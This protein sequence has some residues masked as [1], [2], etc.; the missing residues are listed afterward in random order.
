MNGNFSGVTNFIW[1]IADLLRDIYKRKDYPDVILPFTVLRRLDCVLS[2]T[3]EPV[4]ETYEKYYGKLEDPSAVLM[5]ASGHN[6]YNVS[7]YDFKK[8]LSDPEN[9]KQNMFDYINGFSQNMVEVMER[10]KLR[11]R[12]NYLAEKDLLFKVVQ[13][14]S[15]VDLSPEAVSNH[16]MGYIFEE[17]IRKFSEENNEEAGEHFT[18]REIIRLMVNILMSE[19]K[20]RLSKPGIITTVYDPACGTGGMLTV[21][22][23]HILSD[24]N[25]NAN[26]ELF[27]QEINDETFAVCKSDMI[28]KGENPDNIKPDS[29]FSHDGFLN[30]SFDYILSNPPFGKDWRQDQKFIEDEHERGF[31]G[32]FGAGLPRIDDGQF[33]FLQHMISKMHSP[34]SGERTRIAIVFNGS[35]LFTG[36]AGSGESEIRRWIIENDYLDAIIAM[37]DQLFY[38]T[39]INTYLWIL[40]SRKGDARREKVSLIDARDLFVVMKKNLG[41]KRKE[42]FHDQISEITDLYLHNM[43]NGRIKIFDNSDFGYRKIT[44]DRPL[45]LRF[46]VNEENI[47]RINEEKVFQGKK[48]QA[49]LIEPSEETELIK[50]AIMSLTGRKF[51][52]RVEFEK[53]LETILKGNGVRISAT[54]W[55]SIF[56]IFGTRDDNAEIVRDKNGN[57][58]PD[59]E[60]RDYE[61]VPLKE[62]INK[63]FER[64][65]KPFVPDAWINTDVRDQKDGKI[66]KVGYEISFNRY[67]YKFVSP[68]P[69]EEIDADL[70]KLGNEIIDLLGEITE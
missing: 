43:E 6:F 9:I 46:D 67:F 1:N 17:L 62:D 59:T 14:F 19:D 47:A 12:I 41:Q 52:S 53:E 68:R 21:A 13:K 24:I 7:K 31:S 34:E 45:R 65:V 49:K 16:D 69:L 18:P 33:L 11:E 44:V 70:K 60:S 3:K 26:V 54:Q 63:Y 64:E 40:N 61:N 66:G 4:L 25:S 28:I 42:I 23:D 37:P 10:F 20:E 22:K 55:K 38:N 32:R 15:E 27:G 5:K 30:Q 48:N 51:T 56:K 50:N 35:P 57:P 29:S 2:T 8:L 36:D 39:N 58:E